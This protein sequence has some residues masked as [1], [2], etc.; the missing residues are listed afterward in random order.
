MIW[1]HTI[2]VVARMADREAARVFAGC[3][4]IGKSVCGDYTP[5]ITMAPIS[6]LPEASLP[7]PTGTRSARHN[8]RPK[9]RRLFG[10]DWEQSHPASPEMERKFNPI[11]GLKLTTSARSMGVLGPVIRRPTP[12]ASRVSVMLLAAVRQ[13]FR[14]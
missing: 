5:P 10:C 12:C 1:I 8:F 3:Q 14:R 4:E 2:P 7:K 9:E 13:R 11:S 6:S